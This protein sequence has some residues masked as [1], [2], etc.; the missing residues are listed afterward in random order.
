MKKLKQSV[1]RA[2]N[3]ISIVYKRERNFKLHCLI[4]CAVLLLGYTLG[5]STLQW[6]LIT[7]CIGLVLALE[8]TNSVIEYTWNH[9]EPN[10]HPVVGTIK[11]AMAG[12]VLIVSLTSAIAGILIIFFLK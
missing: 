2:L 7:L 6:I 12:A 11:D 4:A 8:V 3:G 9:L 1:R 10:H 5:F